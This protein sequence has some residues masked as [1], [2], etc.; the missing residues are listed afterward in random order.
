VNGA[1]QGDLSPLA[2]SSPDLAGG[3][4]PREFN[5]DGLGLAVLLAAARPG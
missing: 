3:K 1:S 5:C 2:V 4:F